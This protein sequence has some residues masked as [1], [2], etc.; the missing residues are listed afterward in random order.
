MNI[1]FGF[2]EICIVA[3]TILLSLGFPSQFWV[4]LSA[5][6]FGAIVRTALNV[7]SKKE[8]AELQRNNLD[9]AKK[10]LADLQNALYIAPVATD[11][12]DYTTH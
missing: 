6:V 7:Q 9:D 8:E 12:K 1:Q 5:G 2:P 3:A 4:L 11:K 10:A